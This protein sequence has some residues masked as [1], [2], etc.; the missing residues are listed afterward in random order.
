MALHHDLQGTVAPA[1]PDPDVPGGHAASDALYGMPASVP[2]STGRRRLVL[3]T[4]AAAALAAFGRFDPRFDP[5]GMAVWAQGASRAADLDTFMMVSSKLTGRARLDRTLGGRIYEALAAVDD[6]IPRQVDALSKWLQAH[7]GVPSDTVTEALR[8]DD[9][10]LA[11]SVTAI[12]S[13]WYLGVVGEVPH[14][15]VVSYERALMF[16][17]VH[18]VL[19]VPSYCRDVPGYWANRPRTV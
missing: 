2:D 4:M 7:G 16:D 5:F 15:S 11:K 9:P 13:G 14:A 17:P 12:V 6:A 3:A 19:P 8:G 18:D 1:L 10:A